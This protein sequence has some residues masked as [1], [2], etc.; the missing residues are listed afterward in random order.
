MKKQVYIQPKAEIVR[1]NVSGDIAEDNI[2][3]GSKTVNSDEIEGKQIDFDENEDGDW[4]DF[5]T[6]S[7]KKHSVWDE[8]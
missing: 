1:L 3:V 5:S 6:N 2:P 7:F 4:G 8:F